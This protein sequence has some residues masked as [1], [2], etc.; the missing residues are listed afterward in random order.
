MR[1]LSLIKDDRPAAASAVR[2]C[3]RRRGRLRRRL[4]VLAGLL[5][6]V[7]VLVPTAR[8]R[9]S[10]LGGCGL[11]ATS[12]HVARSL[13]M[14]PRLDLPA[15]GPCRPDASQVGPVCLWVRGSAPSPA[16]APAGVLACPP[17]RSLCPF[18]L[19]V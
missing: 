3:G 12:E 14:P 16:A 13:L 11:G 4:L 10:P 6:A 9:G 17:P 18:P 2:L 8:R 19:R 15:D 1:P 5:L 7:L